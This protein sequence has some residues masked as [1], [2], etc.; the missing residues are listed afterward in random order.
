MIRD[1]LPLTRRINA[2]LLR[3]RWPAMM[4]I[5]W[6]RDVKD[7]IIVRHEY[8]GTVSLFVTKRHVDLSVARRGT[9]VKNREV[10]L[11]HHSEDEA[12]MYVMSVFEDVWTR[13]IGLE[14]S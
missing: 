2:E 9:I 4:A 7:L 13:L 12:V 3:R 14:S 1:L 10:D 6:S 11:T 5:P 8:C